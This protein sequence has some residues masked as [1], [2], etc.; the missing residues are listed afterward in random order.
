MGNALKVGLG[1]V[2]GL[3]VANKVDSYVKAK[4]AR[5]TLL[6][7]TQQDDEFRKFAI[8]EMERMANEA[9]PTIH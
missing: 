9:K 5:D 4:F 2:C 7:M 6:M 8:Q 3:F 1:I